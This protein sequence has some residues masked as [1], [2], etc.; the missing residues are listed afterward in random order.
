MKKAFTLIELLVVVLI[1]GVLSA[2]A[3]PQYRKTVNKTRATEARIAIRTINDA[4]KSYYLAN[5]SYPVSLD[6]LD[7]GIGSFGT[8]TVGTD[9]KQGF[10]LTNWSILPQQVSSSGVLQPISEYQ[11]RGNNIDAIVSVTVGSEGP[12]S[13]YGQD[14]KDVAS[15]RVGTYHEQTSSSAAYTSYTYYF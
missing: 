5:G 9:Q 4:M 11:L 15:S 7:V 1:L 6:M 10:T 14:C 8:V 3:L 2:I 12:Y 13:C